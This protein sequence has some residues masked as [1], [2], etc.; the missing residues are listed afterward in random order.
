MHILKTPPRKH[1][2]DHGAKIRIRFFALRMERSN[3]YS[4]YF[5]VYWQPFVEDHMKA[6]GS[7]IIHKENSFD[8]DSGFS[9]G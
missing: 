4:P 2:I 3:F 1:P 8:W 6:K 7:K 5:C 9:D